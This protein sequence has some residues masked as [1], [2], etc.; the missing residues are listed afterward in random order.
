MHD[1]CFQR[2]RL[3][4]GPLR[5]PIDYATAPGQIEVTFDAPLDR[6]LAEDPESYSLEQWNYLWS[7]Q[8]GSKDWSIRDPKKNGRDTVAVKAAKLKKDNR[9]VVLAVPGLTKAMQFELKYDMD[10]ANGKLVRG[11]M[12]GTINEL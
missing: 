3:V 10:D 1:G 9:T 6:E 8:Y 4:N 2:L 5:Q 7:S 12:A 11:S